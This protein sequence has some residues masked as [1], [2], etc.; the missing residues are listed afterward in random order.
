MTMDIIKDNKLLIVG[1][2]GV[3][4][5]SFIESM[6]LTQFTDR[7]EELN[8]SLSTFPTIVIII[9]TILFLGILARYRNQFR[10]HYKIIRLTFLPVMFSLSIMGYLLGLNVKRIVGI[11][12]SI[13]YDYIFPVGITIA[14]CVSLLFSHHYIV[15]RYLSRNGLIIS[16]TIIYTL[17]LILTLLSLVSSF[18]LQFPID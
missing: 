2:L 5:F 15:K 4:I 13:H 14:I 17:F 7:P 11:E 12:Q 8:F 6:R 10:S 18:I 1:G 16:I 9:V 3:F